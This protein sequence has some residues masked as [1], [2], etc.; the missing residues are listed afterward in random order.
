MYGV[1]T[2]VSRADQERLNS[3]NLTTGSANDE[4]PQDEGDES[5]DDHG[6]EEAEDEDQPD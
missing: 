2:S 4:Q 1:Y 5:D 6:G 3:I